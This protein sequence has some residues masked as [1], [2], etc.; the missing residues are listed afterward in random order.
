MYFTR[1][2]DYIKNTSKVT[3]GVNI[4]VSLMNFWIWFHPLHGIQKALFSV[5]EMGVGNI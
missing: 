1:I 3:H 5:Q 4:K 2:L